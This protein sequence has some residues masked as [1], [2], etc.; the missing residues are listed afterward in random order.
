MKLNEEE[1]FKEFLAES[2]GDGV[3]IRE[4][5]LSNDETE[6][7]KRI[8]PK[9][10]LNKSLT[11]ETLDGKVW[12]KVTLLPPTKNNQESTKS[13]EIAAIQKENQQLKQELEGLKKS[14]VFFSE[15]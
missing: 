7:I 12:Y 10:K 15:N 6:Y 5:R 2:F 8:Y 3:T 13:D 4:L 9:A 14:M 1:K 11:R